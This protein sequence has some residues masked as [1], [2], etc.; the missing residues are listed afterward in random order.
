MENTHRKKVLN[1]AYTIM[2]E[3]AAEFNDRM[4]QKQQKLEMLKM[5]ASLRR[6]KTIEVII[7]TRN[8]D[9]IGMDFT[10]KHFIRVP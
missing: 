3:R 2:D 6:Q 7:E 1:D 8:Y 5:N 9:M 4:S 10:S